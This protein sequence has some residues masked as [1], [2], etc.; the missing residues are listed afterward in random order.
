MSLE[1]NITWDWKT[2]S[3]Q[4]PLFVENIHL[5]RVESIRI[6]SPTRLLVKWKSI[7][8]GKFQG[9]EI[10]ETFDL[11]RAK[12]RVTFKDFLL[13]VCA[14]TDGDIVDLKPCVGRVA[15]VMAVHRRAGRSWRCH[16]LHHSLDWNRDVSV[17]ADDTSHGGHERR[18]EHD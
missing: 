14:R 3:V 15:R 4:Y 2:V 18:I 1:V 11:S 13:A 5:L 10:S 16:I 9:Q 12:G 7:T 6:Q 8:G 17:S